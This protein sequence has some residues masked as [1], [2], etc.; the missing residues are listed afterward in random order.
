LGV[1]FITQENGVAGQVVHL[2]RNPDH[3]EKGYFDLVD[4]WFD[5]EEDATDWYIPPQ[6]NY[7]STA[8]N[9]Y[10]F[11]CR[12]YKPSGVESCQLV[13][14]YEIYITR[15]HTFMSPIMTYGDLERIL[16]AIDTKMTQC[17]GM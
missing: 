5:S 9:H 7:E 1:G 2:G 14:Q 8:A 17:L 4:S 13:G 11:G 12:T 15:F 3:A 10:R 16:V 6:F